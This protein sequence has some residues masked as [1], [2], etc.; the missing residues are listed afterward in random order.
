MTTWTDVTDVSELKI[1]RIKMNVM[2]SRYERE[3]TGRIAKA[4]GQTADYMNDVFGCILAGITPISEL[5][6]HIQ[7]AADGIYRMN[8]AAMER[9]MDIWKEMWDDIGYEWSWRT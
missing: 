4:I 9:E 7:I 2:F 1:L 5:E 6:Y 8:G 3:Y